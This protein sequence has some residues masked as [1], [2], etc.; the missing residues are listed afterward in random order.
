M[1]IVTL[2]LSL[3]DDQFF[4]L[5]L[6]KSEEVIKKWAERIVNVLIHAAIIYAVFVLY[7]L[8]FTGTQIDAEITFTKAE[9]NAILGKLLTFTLYIGLASLGFTVAR[10]VATSVLDS[11]GTFGKLKVLLT[12]IFYSAIAVMIFI[13]TTVSICPMLFIKYNYQLKI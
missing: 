10:N 13:A 7:R 1:L 2:S 3:L 6:R 5:K 8:K 12:T 4:F 9:F 11:H